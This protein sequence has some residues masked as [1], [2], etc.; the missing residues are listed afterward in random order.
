MLELLKIFG[1]NQSGGAFCGFTAGAC[2]I[3]CSTTTGCTFFRAGGAVGTFGRAAVLTD[4]AVQ[5]K[6][7]DL[8]GLKE[9]VIVGRLIPAGTGHYINNIRKLANARDKVL[10]AEAGS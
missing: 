4:S 9:N 1:F 5:G 3:D 10:E 7:D 2:G 8:L 6:V